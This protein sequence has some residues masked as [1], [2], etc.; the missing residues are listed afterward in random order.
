MVS[1]A[2]SY[3]GSEKNAN[4]QVTTNSCDWRPSFNKFRALSTDTDLYPDG[5]RTTCYFIVHTRQKRNQAAL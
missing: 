2:E 4:F 3:V 1:T 5:L